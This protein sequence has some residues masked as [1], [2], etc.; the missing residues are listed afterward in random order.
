MIVALAVIPDELEVVK[1]LFHKPVLVSA[2]FLAHRTKVHGVLD[3]E[4]V[5]C[6]TER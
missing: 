1:G 6:E 3:D 5:I 4:S 2:E